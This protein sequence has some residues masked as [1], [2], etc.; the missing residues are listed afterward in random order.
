MSR[1][2][3]DG[4]CVG[5]A[6]A[7]AFEPGKVLVVTALHCLQEGKKLL[8]ATAFGG[9]TLQFVLANP[10][11][12]LTVFKVDC[13]PERALRSSTQSSHVGQRVDLKAYP[14]AVDAKM[15]QGRTDDQAIYCQGCVVRTYTT[16]HIVL[17]DYRGGA[18]LHLIMG[19]Y[20]G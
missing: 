9:Q 11:H 17:A 18:S 2:M 6:A 12:D 19:H 14:L 4:A 15:A 10:C 5:T 1:V 13:P 7:V 16:S 8:T 20:A 3:V